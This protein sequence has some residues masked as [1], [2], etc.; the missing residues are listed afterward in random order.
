MFPYRSQL[1]Q[2][3]KPKNYQQQFENVIHFKQKP[4][5]TNSQFDNE[6]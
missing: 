3:L 6:R 5:E 4:I 1:V 2:T